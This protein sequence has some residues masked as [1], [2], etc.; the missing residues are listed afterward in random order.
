LTDA[1]GNYTFDGLPPGAFTIS[2]E[3]PNNLGGGEKRDFDLTEHACSEQLFRAVERANLRG[4]IL[5]DHGRAVETTQV[6]MVS[7]T[8]PRQTFFDFT[9]SEGFFTIQRLPSGNYVLG[10]N[11]TEPPRAGPY[12][13]HP[14]SP[15][16]FP[17]VPLREN[18]KI[19]HVESGEELT[20]FD[21]QLSLPLV[22]RTI[23]GRVTWPDGQPARGAS[24]ELKDS[25]FPESN[26]D[27]GTAE[28]DGSFIVTGVEG[29]VYSLSAIIG[30]PEGQK[31]FHSETIQLK[32]Q[33]NE[34]L[35]LVLSL[36]GRN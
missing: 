12:L 8:N 27:L 22:Q 33:D 34:G 35:H 31:S 4:M 10:V 14:F 2:A 5:D 28:N 6:V 15:A 36:S 13:N 17:G 24:V 1:A 26:V 32:S 3:M 30:I 7:T 9:D 20:G 16:F 18:A 11:I 19:I 21:L 25:E 23:T 29:R